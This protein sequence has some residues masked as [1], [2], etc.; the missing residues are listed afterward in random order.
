MYIEQNREGCSHCV[1]FG[2]FSNVKVVGIL[3]LEVCC[4]KFA[5]FSPPKILNAEDVVYSCI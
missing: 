2:S 1:Y 3:S 5:L 4:Q